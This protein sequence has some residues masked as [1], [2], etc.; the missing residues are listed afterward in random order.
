MGYPD[1]ANLFKKSEIGAQSA[2]KG[3]SSQTL[4]IASRIASDTGDHEFFPEDI[5]DLVIKIDG[6]IVEAVQIKNISSDLTLSSLASTKSSR[7]GVG[8]FIR[9]CNLHINCPKF[10]KIRIVYFN[11]LGEEIKGFLSGNEDC[12][13]S[14]IKKLINNHDITLDCAEWLLSSLVFEK[15]SIEQLQCI[16]ISQLKDYVPIMAAPELAK[17]LLV[18]HIADLSEIKRSINL[19][20]WQELIYQIGT[21][22]AAIDGYYKEYQ[23]SLLRLCDLTLVKEPGLLASEFEQGVSAH[24]THIRN[25]LDIQRTFWLGKI[26][27]MI[28][29]GKAVI[30]KGV[31]GQ[32]KSALCYR[33]LINNHP[34]ELVFCIRRVESGRQAEN[35][36]IALKGISKHTQNMVVYIDVNPGEQQWVLLIQELQIRG[37]YVPVLVSIREEDYKLAKLDGSSINFKIID[38]QLSEQE[39]ST[40]YHLSTTAFPHPQFRSFEEAWSRFGSGGPLLEF[41][42]LLTY[43]QTLKQRL[44]AQIDNLFWENHPDSWFSLLQLVCFAG[45]TCCPLN[46]NDLKRVVAC[47]DAFTAIQRLSNEYLIRR[48]EDGV[49]VEALHPLRAQIICDVLKEKIGE[50]SIAL[51]LS[52][53]EC[54]DSYCIQLFLMDYFSGHS[55]SPEIVSEIAA[56]EQRDWIACAGLIKTMLWLD[57]KQYVEQNYEVIKML[58]L[59]HGSGW[60]TFMPLDISGLICSD[61]IFV[62]RFIPLLQNIKFQDIKAETNKIKD[63]LTSLQIGYVATDLLIANCLPPS[64]IPVGDKEWSMFGY[65]L[66][67]LAKRKRKIEIPFTIGQMQEKMLHGDIKSRAD[68]IRGM[69]EQNCEGY[70]NSATKILVGRLIEDYCF[71]HLNITENK[72]QCYCIPPVFGNETT[73]IPENFNHYWKMKVFNILAQLYFEKEYIEVVLA[74]VNLLR[75][76]GIEAIDHRM[77]VHKDNRHNVWVTEINSW[78]KSRIDYYYRPNSWH[79]YINRIDQVRRTACRLV[80]DTTG[81]IEFLFKKKRHSKER[82][83]KL[84]ASLKLLDGLLFQDILLPINVVDPYCLYRED[85]RE[86]NLNLEKTGNSTLGLSFSL[87]NGFKKSFDDTYRSLKLFY[88]QFVEILLTRIRGE[89]LDNIDNP[90]LPIIYLFDSA[91][92]IWEMQKEYNIFFCS[93][94]TLEN[95]FEEKEIEGML[96]LLNMCVHVLE[97]LPKG[98]A[99]AYDAKQ[100]YRR[101]CDIVEKAFEKALNLIGGEAYQIDNKTYIFVNSNMFLDDAL[102][103]NY[104]NVVLVLRDVYRQALPYNSVRWYLE[105]QSPELIFVPTYNG[106]PISNGYQLP[107]YRILN[108]DENQLSSVLFPEDIPASIFGSKCE[109]LIQWR[110]AAGYLGVVQMQIA[111]YNDVINTLSSSNF[112]CEKGIA[113][114]VSMLCHQLLE[115]T[116]KFIDCTALPFKALEVVA[117]QKVEDVFDMIRNII[118][119]IQTICDHIPVLEKIEGLEEKIHNVI[120]YMLL[121]QSH[122]LAGAHALNSKS[123]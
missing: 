27:K 81:Y 74:G 35:L 72:V 100:L 98:Y 77:K 22:L 12:K 71:I 1:R 123:I 61:E 112:K 23:K 2:W 121:L 78:V 117:D 113:K 58:I 79:D 25:G 24:P 18:Q 37:V 19:K 116:T 64:G 47:G 34:E 88:Q 60:F 16:I 80:S 29:K 92:A 75:D 108:V 73:N 69:I 41:M 55:F 95:G 52:V 6:I 8:F 89:N 42:Y 120:G 3:F 122:V 68:A 56:V 96:I 10:S 54:V 82:W 87:Y 101:S 38:L 118:A 17:A 50:N 13:K 44:Q 30:V 91:K 45:Q 21:D 51:M 109:E 97:N 119:E 7:R 93:Y 28:G 5:E 111:Q 62:E 33:Y 59:E 49:Y 67:W 40:I 84:L 39:A 114:Y 104:K 85:I 115:M 63:S 26:E 36:A 11:K 15:V 103:E 32:G 4:Y 110:L 86:D 107:I 94:K 14:I 43:N 57:V 48:T 105:T 53:L 9:V 70:S 83:D 76:L 31:S 65:S 102:E 90:L 20:Q 99:I 46:L 106:L 66:F